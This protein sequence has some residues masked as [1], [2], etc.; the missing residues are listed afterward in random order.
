[1]GMALFLRDLES[2]APVVLHPRPMTD[3]EFLAFCGEYPDCF[4][5]SNAEGEI[6]IMP[7]AGPETSTRNVRILVPLQVWADADGRGEVTESSS[8]FRLP[9]GA[10]RAPDAAWVSHERLAQVP[11]SKRGGIF[12]T[13]PEFVI[14]LMPPS[15]RLR[16]AQAKMLEYMENEVLLGWLIDP[17]KRVVYVYRPGMAAEILE[18]PKQVVGEGPVEGFVLGLEYVWRGYSHIGAA[19]SA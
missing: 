17:R 18:S 11:A 2:V 12:R 15:D 13:A 5:E 6:I 3:E 8:G 7:P 19:G 16:A 14:E 10:R 9:N 4:I 1:M